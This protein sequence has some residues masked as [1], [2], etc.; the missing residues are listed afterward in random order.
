VAGAII[1]VVDAT[2]LVQN[3]TSAAST[4]AEQPLLLSV[5]KHQVPS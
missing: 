3:R 1:A 2:I 4:L 5:Q